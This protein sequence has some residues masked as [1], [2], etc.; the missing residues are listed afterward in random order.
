MSRGGTDISG[1]LRGG[2]VPLLKWKVAVWV[3]ALFIHCMFVFYS[4]KWV[5]YFIKAMFPVLTNPQ[6]L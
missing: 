2:G 5:F 3:L 6:K 1:G 4:Q